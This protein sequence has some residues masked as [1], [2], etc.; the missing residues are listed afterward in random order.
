[1]RYTDKFLDEELRWKAEKHKH[2]DKVLAFRH[3][4]N[5]AFR[6]K[7]KEWFKTLDTIGVIV[8]LFN[9]LAIIMTGLLV[10]KI[11]P[12]QVIVE[13][14]P[15]QCSWN[16]FSCHDDAANV[17]SS[18][19]KQLLIWAFLIGLYIFIRNNIYSYTGLWI[20]TGIVVLYIVATSY[21]LANDLGL[22]LGKVL[23][24]Q[25]MH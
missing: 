18:V 20:M 10:V 25:V 2:R 6:K 22:Y 17:M 19:Y 21:D 14:N 23:F 11:V 9:L 7:H 4:A 13:G 8:I 15:A 24:A 5:K 3:K 1:M 16:G 12:N